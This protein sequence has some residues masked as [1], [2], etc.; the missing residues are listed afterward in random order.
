[1]DLVDDEDA[2]VRRLAELVLRVD[3]DEPALG[4]DRLPAGEERMAIAAAA[5]KSSAV[6]LPVARISSRDPL[7]SCSPLGAFVAWA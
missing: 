1:V 3:E 7:T 6:T 2:P 5:S 4:A